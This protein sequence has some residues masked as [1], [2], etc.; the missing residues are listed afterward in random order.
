MG[1]KILSIDGN[2][3]AGKTSLLEQVRQLCTHRKDII[4]VTEPVEEFMTFQEQFKPFHCQELHPYHES[5]A[6]QMH[7]TNV[8]LKRYFAVFNSLNADIKLMICD[9]YIHAVPAFIE[10]L[11]RMGYISDF[12]H[13]I[14][15]SNAK[16]NLLRVLPKADFVYYLDPPLST[17]ESRIASRGREGECGF[18][19]RG[20]LEILKEEYPKCVLTEAVDWKRNIGVQSED[21]VFQDFITFVNNKMAQS[22]DTTFT[23]LA[24]EIHGIRGDGEEIGE[25]P[26]ELEKAGSGAMVTSSAVRGNESDNDDKADCGA[27]A[28]S[29]A[30]RENETINVDDDHSST[31]GGIREL[32]AT[33]A[34][35][36]G[37]CWGVNT[38]NEVDDEDEEEQGIV[39]K[40][41][42][43]IPGV[44]HAPESLVDLAAKAVMKRR[45][46][47]ST[48]GGNNNFPDTSGPRK[49]IVPTRLYPRTIQYIKL[50]C[51]AEKPR[52]GSAG[53]A[54]YDLTTIQPEMLLPNQCTYIRTGIAL[55]LPPNCYGRILDRSSVAFTHK[56]V[57]VGGVIDEDY[58]GEI[59][60]CLMNLKK[61]VQY[62]PKG[63][64]IAQI[65]FQRYVNVDMFREVTSFDKKSDRGT[66]GFGSTGGGY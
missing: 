50:H 38:M 4:F 49:R 23:P 63:V 31:S 9:R 2:I 34:S 39:K 64:R 48:E 30:A 65:V 24:S 12:S 13:A 18:L 60:I 15:L 40:R 37:I 26:I 47:S 35:R 20:Y 27:M 11:R 58:E 29:S 59:K 62:I 5:V 33:V 25:S 14:L 55:N 57:T 44:S 10:A 66:A 61:K 28:S 8:L 32:S 56:L 51:D 16:D 19:T 54:G 7:I 46:W 21:I 53:A 1:V 42:M 36:S 6:V 45:M 22:L 43:E 52:R 3:G 41:K 17:I